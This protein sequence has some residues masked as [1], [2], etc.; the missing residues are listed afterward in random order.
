MSVRPIGPWVLLK[1]D[2]PQR[3]SKGGLYLPEGNMEER[4]GHGA[5]TVLAVGSGKL[6]DKGKR[7]PPGISEGDRVMFRGYL[8]ELHQPGGQFDK[9]QC[10]IHIDDIVATLGEASD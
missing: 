4:L 10:L 8:K 5:G 2:P 7:V 6:D 3:K 1:P 9:D